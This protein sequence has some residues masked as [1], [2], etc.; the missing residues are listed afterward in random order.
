MNLMNNSD[1]DIIE[2]LS[3]QESK[4]ASIKKAIRFYI[5][6]EKKETDR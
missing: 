2:W 5:E 4:Q 1:A 6:N 3:K